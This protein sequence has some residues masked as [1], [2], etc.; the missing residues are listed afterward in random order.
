[1]RDVAQ[2]ANRVRQVE[3][4]KT[5]KVI[6]LKFSKNKVAHVEVDNIGNLSDSEYEYVEE[7]EVNVSELKPG[8]PYTYKLLKLSNGKNPVEPKNGFFFARTYTFDV[9]K[10]DKIFNLLV[11]D[12]QTIVPKGNKVPLLEQRKNFFFVV[13]FINFWVIILLNDKQK[14][15]SEEENETKTDAFFVEP[16]DI[17]VVNTVTSARDEDKKPND[18]DQTAKAYPK[19]EKELINFLNQCKLEDSEVMSCPRCSSVFD[20]EAA[21]E[22]EKTNPY[23]AKKFV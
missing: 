14:P 7:N 16:V 11:V 21:K 13:N 6:T 3:C 9:T 4:L 20:K 19:H 8:P 17:M 1:M 15:R 5:E 2:L 12:R 22:M 18:E 10:C 23:Q